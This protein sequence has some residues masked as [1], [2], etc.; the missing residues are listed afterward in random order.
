MQRT[1]RVLIVLFTALGLVGGGSYAL[2][3]GKGKD[4][5]KDH[6]GQGL[7]KSKEHKQHKHHDGKSLL[8][9]KAKTNGHHVFHQN[10]KFT[11]AADVTNGKIAGLKVKHADKGDVPVKKYKTTKKMAEL[12]S[13]GFQ[14][15]AFNLAQ[16]SQYLGVTWIGYSYYDDYGD[17]VIYWFPYDMILDGDTGAIEYYP[18]S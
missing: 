17:E 18:A 6:Q 13:S 9:D 8:G 3:Q 1:H 2:A 4:K 16:S 12:P 15:V 11:A 5:D 7:G 10:G 14:T